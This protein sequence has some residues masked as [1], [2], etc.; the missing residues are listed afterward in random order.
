[1]SISYEAP[2]TI[3]KE[4]Y[5][6]LKQQGVQRDSHKTVAALAKQGYLFCM[7]IQGCI[8]SAF[9][10]LLI[11]QTRTFPAEQFKQG[12]PAITWSRNMDADHPIVTHSHKKAYTEFPSHSF[13]KRSIYRSL[14]T[15]GQENDL[16]SSDILG[17]GNILEKGNILKSI[18]TPG[19]ENDLK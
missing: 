3:D 4:Y 14:E 10:C 6:L 19:Q 8:F 9:I 17:K 16:K 1:M 18:D 15:L 2:T 11:V 7:A 13:V 12:F 5:R